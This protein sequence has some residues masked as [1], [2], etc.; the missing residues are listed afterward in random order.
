MSALPKDTALMA[1]AKPTMTFWST[2]QTCNAPKVKGGGEHTNN[3]NNN[4][5]GHHGTTTYGTGKLG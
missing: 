4:K 1:C 5:T 2:Q 3:N